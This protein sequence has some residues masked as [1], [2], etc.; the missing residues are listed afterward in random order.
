MREIEVPLCEWGP[1]GD[2]VSL[3][4]ASLS[5]WNSWRA[6]QTVRSLPRPLLVCHHLN[7]YNFVRQRSLTSKSISCCECIP[8]PWERDQRRSGLLKLE[9]VWLLM[10]SRGQK[11][12]SRYWG[13]AL[14]WG[15]PSQ[16]AIS[17]P[18]RRDT[19]SLSSEQACP[20]I[21]II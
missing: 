4:S 15:C 2:L 1:I 10:C 9:S 6:E 14:I 17:A 12:L 3:D 16:L 13:N 11:R 21:L 19:Y 7:I 18:C 20:Y 5:E 8:L